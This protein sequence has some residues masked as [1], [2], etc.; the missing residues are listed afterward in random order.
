MYRQWQ[1]QIMLLDLH[2]PVMDGYQV[3]QAMS[4]EDKR[5][6]P[7]IAVTASNDFKETQH[8]MTLGAAA[9]SEKPYN[10]EKILQLVHVHLKNAAKRYKNDDAN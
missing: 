6:C 3:L 1:P 9:V 5:L 10:S 7:V 4:E 8:L 2:M